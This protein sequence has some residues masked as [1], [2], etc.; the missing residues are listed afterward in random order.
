ML[1]LINSNRMI[2]PIAP[3]GLDYVGGAARGAGWDVELVDLN[4]ADD[5]ASAIRGA[6]AAKTPEL[7]GVTFRNVDDCFWPGAGWFLPELEAVVGAVRAASDA[8]IVLGGVGFSL[9][10][11]QIVEATGADF[12]VHGDG[13]P[14]IVGLLDELR[15]P[16]RFDR[17]PGLLW[18]DGGTVR[19]NPPAWPTTVAPPTERDT[20]DNRRYLR[21]GGQIGLET[22]RGCP[23]GC[24]YC[25]DPLAKGA[26]S[27]LRDPAEV[28]REAESL[29][30]RGI[31]VLHVCDSEFNLPRNHAL[32]V[33]RALIGRGL[34]ERLRWY[35]YLAVL[36]FDAEQAAAMRRAGCVGINFTTD[37]ACDPMLALF[38]HPHRRADIAAAVGRC[39]REGIAVMLDLLIGGPG[40]TPQTLAESIGF[41]KQ[42]DPDCVGAAL[43]V[44]LYPGTAVAREVTAGGAEAGIHRRYAG[45][46]DFVRPTFYVAPEL[47]PQPARLVRELAGD[48]PRFFL[49]CDEEPAASPATPSGDPWANY[50]YSANRALA[51][52]IAAGAR[53]AYWDILRRQRGSPR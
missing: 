36:P 6:L 32:E 19:A 1:L 53:G 44:R 16:R 41:L 27:R 45:P 10:A 14:A 28:A 12:G 42:A 35:A 23:R 51:D 2:P 33:C 25:A 39:R 5:P 29:L 31:D 18:R 15:G 43:G 4:W 38:R 46:L 34:G 47:G 21:F 17:V 30:A 3:I 26:S 50:N 7:V 22:K 24:P 52:S 20:A 49:P 8:P 48:D 13:E 11:K 37:S 40:E 9:F